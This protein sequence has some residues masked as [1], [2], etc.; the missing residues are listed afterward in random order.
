MMN[1]YKIRLLEGLFVL[2]L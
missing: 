2:A 1:Y